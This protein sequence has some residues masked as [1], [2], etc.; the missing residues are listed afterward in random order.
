MRRGRALAGFDHAM[1]HHR[2]SA[3]STGAVGLGGHQLFGEVSS[4][5][6]RSGGHRRDEALRDAFCAVARRSARK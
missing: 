3:G 1:H 6:N 4:R 5:L 2:E